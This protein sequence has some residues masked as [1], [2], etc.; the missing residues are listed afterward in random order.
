MAQPYHHALSNLDHG[1]H[2]TPDPTKSKPSRVYAPNPR[3]HGNEL[4]YH[5]LAAGC[6]YFIWSSDAD[7]VLSEPDSAYFTIVHD[8]AGTVNI[9]VR[10][11]YLD[12]NGDY[13][14]SEVLELESV[15]S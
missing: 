6:D 4:T 1:R 10:C 3:I 7:R 5:A 2:S 13:D 8:S 14:V 11:A 15:I 12:E 9:G